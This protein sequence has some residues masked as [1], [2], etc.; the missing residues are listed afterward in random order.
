MTQ[1]Q[2]AEELSVHPNRVTGWVRGHGLPKLHQL[3]ELAERLDVPLDWLLTGRR[4]ARAA[5]R[6]LVGELAELAP[7]LA[8]LATRAQRM[9]R[10]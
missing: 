6:R 1:R 8:K 10:P 9:A 7:S 2:L 3:V 4:E 5:E